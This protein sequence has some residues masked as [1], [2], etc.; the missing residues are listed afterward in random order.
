MS[1]SLLPPTWYVVKSHSQT[2]RVFP[3]IAQVAIA[4]VMLCPTPAAVGAITGS[5][6][7]SLTETEPRALRHDPHQQA[8]A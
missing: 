2:L 4:L 8:E 5:R 6:T 1:T 3:T 7:R